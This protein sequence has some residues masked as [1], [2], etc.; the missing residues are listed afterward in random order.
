MLDNL[1][2]VVGDAESLEKSYDLEL[3]I[4]SHYLVRCG[5]AIHCASAS[6]RSPD[7]LDQVAGL[8]TAPVVAIPIFMRLGL[9]RAVIRY[10]PERAMWTILQAMTL[11]RW[12]G[13]RCLSL[14]TR[15][16][17]R[18]A[19]LGAGVLL[20]VRHDRHRR[21]PFPRQGHARRPARAW[22]AGQRPVLIYGAGEAGVQLAAT[23]RTAAHSFVVGFLDD[24]RASAGPRRRR[25]ARLSA[26]ALPELIAEYGVTR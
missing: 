8:L 23:L 4:S 2:D 24:D 26:S 7:R 11:R 15:D 18:R 19:A 1:K 25:H 14:R 10:L 6:G 17:R 22:R 9:Y 5:S 3:L 12:A 21:Q 20:A 13:W 16:P